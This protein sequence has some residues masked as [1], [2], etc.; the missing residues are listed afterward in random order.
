MTRLHQTSTIITLLG[1]FLAFVFSINPSLAQ[2]DDPDLWSDLRDDAFGENR[3][4]LEE[5]GTVVLEAPYRAEDASIVPI[6]IRIPARIAPK[7]RTLT[8]FVEKNPMPMV[9]KLTY[10]KGAG[11]GERVLKTRIRI[12][13]YSNVRA[14]IELQDGTL[15]MATK[16]VKASGGCSAAAMKDADEALA[17]LGKIKVR[18]FSTKQKTSQSKPRTREAQVMVRHPNYSGMQ[19]NPLTGLYIPAKYITEMVV[20]QGE[21]LIFKMEGGISL[22]E[23]PNFRFTYSATGTGPLHAT[24]KDS[25]GN[26]F[27]TQV[28]DAQI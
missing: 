17:S 2:N 10:G 16:F 13:M 24:A 8:L 23:D 26:I 19:M 3:T 28:K 6:T 1:A 27:K 14:V 5:D 7:V 11:L 4:V 18:T 12:N 20:S 22:S 25:D 9:A 15:H 21:A